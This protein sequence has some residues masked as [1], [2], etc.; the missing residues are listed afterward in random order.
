MYS[1]R[2]SEDEYPARGGPG[3]SSGYLAPVPHAR[4]AG[5]AASRSDME[6]PLARSAAPPA[7]TAAG[8]YA[9]D[10]EGV[11]DDDDKF[12]PLGTSD[13]SSTYNGRTGRGGKAEA[14][15]DLLRGKR[16]M[17]DDDGDADVDPR[18]R[19][20]GL[21]NVQSLSW[22]FTAPSRPPARPR[23]LAARLRTA[24]WTLGLGGGSLAE[25]N[26]FGRRS[27]SAEPRT[28]WVNDVERN[29]A[30]GKAAGWKGNG[31]GTGKYNVVTFLPKF[32]IGVSARLDGGEHVRASAYLGPRREQSN[33]A[34]MPTCS[35]SLPVSRASSRQVGCALMVLP[36]I[37]PASSKSPASRRRA[38][39]PRSSRSG[40]FYSRARTR[41]SRKIS[42][43]CGARR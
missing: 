3:R 11:F 40:S 39:T 28:V 21:E 19:T 10:S 24:D 4:N 38:S 1:A 17:L 41:S 12:G 27:E 15:D 37:Q 7:R 8:G 20:D 14:Y 23:S 35:S 25:L 32:L 13:S 2:R 42:C 26:P 33:S 29:R 18:S 30:E 34:S 9:D 6:L 43:V 31:V 5:A 36:S 16:D 22:D